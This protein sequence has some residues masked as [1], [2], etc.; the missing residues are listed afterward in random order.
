V[1]VARRFTRSIRVDAD[2]ND[3]A[4]LEGYV[5]AQSTVEALLLMARHRAATGHSAFTWTGP[6]GSGKSSLAVA[7]A[8]LLA[9]D[10]QQADQLLRH[11][12]AEE[13]REL[14]QAFRSGDR[15]WSIVPVVGRREDPASVIEQALQ[16]VAH[17]RRGLARGNGEALHR[18][19][20]RIAGDRSHAG[21]LLV[22]D[23]MGKF[24]E[25]A[26][27]GDGD[28][29]LFQELAETAARTNGRLIVVGILHQAFDEY[30][31]RLAREGRD[32]WLK[33][34][35]RFLDIPI[36]LA[37]EE[38]LELIGR[39]IE[40]D[41]PPVSLAVSTVAG[42]LSGSRFGDAA[43]LERRLNA[44]WPLHPVVAALLGPVS[45]RRF[46]QNQRSLFGFL[47]SAEPAGFQAFLQSSEAD[48]AF[49]YPVGRLWDYL[50]INLEPAILASPDGHRW[51]TALEALD[52][53]EAKGATATHLDLLK[54][55][56]L[57]DLFKDRSGLHATQEIL[58]SVLPEDAAVDILLSDLTRWSVAIYR[59]H[60]GAYAI[61]AGSDFDIEASVD[62][63]R[64]SGVAVD[65]RR[66]A[67]RA[68]VQPILAKRHYE[69]TGALRWFEVELTPLHEVEDRV[70]TY[71]PAPGAAGLFL[72]VV[73]AQAEGRE[74][75][76]KILTRAVETAA[77]GRLVVCGW[78]RES[79]VLRD[80]AADLAALEHVRANRPELE[81]DAVARREV[82]A[83]LA[84]L[85]A[86]LEDRLADAIDRVEWY[87]PEAAKADVDSEVSGP[88]GLSVLASRLADW[89]YPRAPRL[90]NE[91][92]NRTRPSSNAQA[93][94]RALLY[95]MVDRAALPR[96]GF[97]S[98]PP[99]AG[100][101]MSVL[102][103]TGLHQQAAG[104]SG[105][106]FV[107]PSETGR[108]PANLAP[109]W[110]A[111]D[112]LL[113]SAPTGAQ[114]TEIFDLWRAPPFGVRDGLLPV[115]WLAYLLS[116]S[117]QSAV[118]L[119]GV[120]RP[121]VDAGLI[122]RLLQ[123]PSD[124]RL[125]R[126]EISDVHAEFISALAD[127]LSTPKAVVAPTALE[128]A[129]AIVARVRALPNWTLRT[130]RLTSQ[131]LVLRDKAKAADDPNRLVLEDLPRAI[132]T[133]L[134]DL[135]G[136]R[137]ARRV[138]DLLDELTDA[139]SAML[140]ELDGLLRRE[141]RIREG[142][143][144]ALGKLAR[145]AQNVLGLAGNFRLDALATRLLTYSGSLEDIDGI[146][147]LAANKPPKDWVDRDVDAA[148]V[149]LA[150]LAQ[151]FLKAEGFGRLKDRED[152]RVAFAVYISDPRYPEPQSREIELTPDERRA[153]ESLASQ[154]GAVV[155]RHG[156]SRDIAIAALAS[157][158]L[159]LGNPTQEGL[160]AVNS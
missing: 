67:Q 78:T 54:A 111:A 131:A 113:N 9:G 44:C 133:G 138:V 8:A 84:R 137:L 141:L 106:S 127:A 96:L 59:A 123:D 13:R 102:E 45:R 122:D 136:L 17:G 29:Y 48:P 14:E 4:A 6:Y 119:E 32:E 36:N 42:A 12:R 11:M 70:G 15:R 85:A 145:R 156:A 40:G 87:L 47:N 105:W 95:A 19:A 116:R 159:S 75:A 51:S 62:E 134:G 93:A 109:L 118:Y 53:A 99:E 129:R 1:R 33:V 158:G 89:R 27:R 88:A 92:L 112:S 140:T 144:A 90:P 124:I 83:R 125:R 28:V 153:A 146:A 160:E 43:A 121:T 23:E 68:A 21:L 103:A 115:L 94:V 26:A 65:Y 3:P 56:A 72:L 142:D 132:E 5:C 38:Q 100:L 126:I 81:G 117:S 63:A 24:L 152:G 143:E 64:R 76:K 97:E 46:G 55:V 104:G 149:E 50:H 91:L 154:L 22:I 16:G 98:Y 82:D 110:E 148:R 128:V 35:G 150:M 31:H 25:G 77:D 41:K 61:Y 39:A 108:D 57:I 155:E 130:G 34:Q 135:A 30:A 107:A 114:V 60:V 79:F 49:V 10:Q 101:H 52:R 20:A 73:S 151:Q 120:F 74:K 147:S 139:Y 157:L 37:A 86:D 58:A 66:L 2:F 71:R 80:M 7:L 18:W 69:A